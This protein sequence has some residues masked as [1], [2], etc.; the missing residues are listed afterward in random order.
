MSEVSVRDERAGVLAQSL[1]GKPVA[2]LGDPALLLE[3]AARQ[4]ARDRLA[5]DGVPLDG[6]PLIGVAPR[7][8]FPPAHRLIPHF[9]AFRLGL[10]DP[11]NSVEGERLRDL[12]ASL[13]DRQVE[14]HGAYI[15]FLPTY[16]VAHE[17]DDRLSADILARMKHP[18]GQVLHLDD[19]A[20][21][22]AVTRELH[23]MLGGRMHPLIFAA[24]VGTPGVGLAYNPKFQ[25]LFDLLGLS[26]HVHDVETFVREGRLDAIE[27]SLKAALAGRRPIDGQLAALRLSLRDFMDR[28]LGVDRHVPR[29]DAA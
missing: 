22:M 16:N 11:Q 28:Q 13:L 6:R 17:G 14:R 4:V 12:L 3:P 24:S 18:E 21:Y 19:P 23:V 27:A 10:P 9:L 2:V 5:G 29:D 25:G 15:L 26:E 20:L 7:R 8:W 1:T